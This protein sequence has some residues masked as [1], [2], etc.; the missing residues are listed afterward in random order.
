[1]LNKDIREEFEY[2]YSFMDLDG[3]GFLSKD[4]L[5]ESNLHIKS[6]MNDKK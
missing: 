4:E 5:I 1:M 3:N 6:C 2:L